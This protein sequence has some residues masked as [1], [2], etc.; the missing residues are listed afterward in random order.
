MTG[1]TPGTTA[2]G[3]S[4][5]VDDATTSSTGVEPDS[6]VG[7]PD[8]MGPPA[9]CG[10]GSVDPGELCFGEPQ[11]YPTGDDPQDIAIADIDNDDALDILT[12]SDMTSMLSILESDG[13]G[14]YTPMVTYDGGQSPYRV[15]VADYDGDGD[16]DIVIAG[17]QLVTYWNQSGFLVQQTSPG[18]FG[19]NYDVNSMEVMDGN[20]DAVPDIGL[21][22]GL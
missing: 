20:G 2:P 13:I 22:P 21:H 16:S 1:V 5:D 9:E 3:T 8:T 10:D 4:T 17:E 15:R 14:G 12:V 7:D 19:G 6:T 11:V 18:G